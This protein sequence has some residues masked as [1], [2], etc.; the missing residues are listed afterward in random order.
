MI[1]LIL[2]DSHGNLEPAVQAIDKTKPDVLIHL[3]DHYGDMLRLARLYPQLEVHGV[4]GNCDL[5][6]GVSRERMVTLEGHSVYL[7]HGDRYGVKSSTADLVHLADRLQPELLLFGHTH[8]PYIENRGS[9][10][11]VNPGSIGRPQRAGAYSYAV[12]E[13]KEGRAP[14]VWVKRLD[15]EC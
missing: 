4:P 11:L 9:V 5:A 2:S 1:V 15:K 13:L 3:G 6:A 8:V 12:A 10:M 14:S 7:C